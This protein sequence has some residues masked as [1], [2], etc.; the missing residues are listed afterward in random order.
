M[1]DKAG[2]ITKQMADEI[3]DLDQLRTRFYNDIDAPI[4]DKLK[5]ASCFLSMDR[6]SIATKDTKYTFQSR[7]KTGKST[8]T[9][10]LISPDEELI[11][12]LFNMGLYMY[13]EGKNSGPKG[14]SGLGITSQ[15]C[16][17]Y[18]IDS[19]K[20][21][22]EEASALGSNTGEA[23]LPNLNQS[24]ISYYMKIIQLEILAQKFLRSQEE[25][26]ESADA[27]R[28]IHWLSRA[29]QQLKG[30]NKQQ[31]KSLGAI[32]A[33]SSLYI[34]FCELSNVRINHQLDQAQ[35]NAAERGIL[36][37]IIIKLYIFKN[38]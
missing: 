20:R 10:A 35:K 12:L 2:F 9:K 3:C 32:S 22:K 13:R 33:N 18:A 34:T 1:I 15:D 5:Y 29:M 11:C 6:G 19:F 36:K 17:E 37:V 4:E 25:S 24:N 16:L 7:V 27:V 30:F 8:K 38:T 31:I 26:Q 28:E 21:C 14:T 23:F